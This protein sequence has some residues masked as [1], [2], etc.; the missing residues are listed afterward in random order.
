MPENRTTQQ[1]SFQQFHRFHQFNSPCGNWWKRVGISVHKINLL[2][3]FFMKCLV[4]SEIC[5]KFAAISFKRLIRVGLW[6]QQIKS[7]GKS[8]KRL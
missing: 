5:S 3:K 1:A 2:K 8:E 6:K 4:L 7:S